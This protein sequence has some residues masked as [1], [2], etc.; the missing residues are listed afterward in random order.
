MG[1]VAAPSIPATHKLDP[2]LLQMHLRSRDNS[3]YQSPVLIQQ[4]QQQH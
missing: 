4:P 3:S 1:E 2:F